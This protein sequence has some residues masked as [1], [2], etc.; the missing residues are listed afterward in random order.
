[1]PPDKPTT[2]LAL[3]SLVGEIG[4]KMITNIEDMCTD[5]THKRTPFMISKNILTRLLNKV[6]FTTNNNTS[7]TIQ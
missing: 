6:R 5:C 1:M 7:S 4:L 3:Y 2:T